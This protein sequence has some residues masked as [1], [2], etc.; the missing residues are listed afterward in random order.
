MATHRISAAALLHEP[1]QKLYAI[2]AD[3]EQ[4]HPAILP[5]PPFVSLEVEA[6][7]RGHGTVIRVWMRVLGRQQSFRAVI[8]EPE[9]G[10][11]LVET[12]DN[13]YVTT[14]TVEPR[15]DGAESYVTIETEIHGRDGLLGALERRFV[16]RLLRPVYV[17]E[18]ENLAAVAAAPAA[19]YA[20]VSP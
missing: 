15:R 13:G 14:F 9:P 19:T 18:L 1:P 7:G 2:L 10:R 3:Y 12:N 20:N 6:G 8:T 16:T 4:G 11:A 5:K 17:R